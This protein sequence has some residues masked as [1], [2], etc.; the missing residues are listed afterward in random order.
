MDEI[1]E[2]EDTYGGKI[3]VKKIILTEGKACKEIWQI[4]NPETSRWYVIKE[5]RLIEHYKLLMV[6]ERSV[7]IEKSKSKKSK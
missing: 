3:K 5:K 4:H 2:F 7:I 6:Q 1:F